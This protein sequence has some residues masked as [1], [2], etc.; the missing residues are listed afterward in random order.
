MNKALDFITPILTILLHVTH[1]ALVDA[2]AT[3]THVLSAQV[4]GHTGT[5]LLVTGVPTVIFIVTPPVSWN[6]FTI[7]TSR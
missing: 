1:P 6:T 4:T 2:L 5:L 7:A 3:V